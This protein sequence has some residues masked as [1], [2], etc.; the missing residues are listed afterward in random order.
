MRVRQIESRFS[1]NC[2]DVRPPLCFEN[3]E[4][5]AVERRSHFIIKVVWNEHLACKFPQVV[6]RLLYARVAF[7]RA[8]TK[9]DKPL[10]A[11][12][13][14]IPNFLA[15]A[16]RNIG[17]PFIAAARQYFKQSEVP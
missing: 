3:L 17:D 1:D 15:C 12:P 5:W 4:M 14:V 13:Q 8:I 11:V 2:S 7:I 10:T 6:E 9:T 16:C